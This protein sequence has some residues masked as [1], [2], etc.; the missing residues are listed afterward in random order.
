MLVKEAPI[1]GDLGMHLGEN[2]IAVDLLEALKMR[3]LYEL[4]QGKY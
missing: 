2:I 3:I 1:G 4:N